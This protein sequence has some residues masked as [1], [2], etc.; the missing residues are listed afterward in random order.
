METPQIIQDTIKDI[1]DGDIVKKIQDGDIFI[2]TREEMI[3]ILPWLRES[4]TAKEKRDENAEVCQLLGKIA[5]LS[6]RLYGTER[7]TH[8][9]CICNG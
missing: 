6:S 2:L 1:Q 4:L 7:F 3:T 8:D 5:T 9:Q